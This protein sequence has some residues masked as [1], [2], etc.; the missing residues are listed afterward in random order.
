MKALKQMPRH[1][2]MYMI[3]LIL[4]SILAAVLW[5]SDPAHRPDGQSRINWP[6]ASTTKP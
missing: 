3:V 2:I 5:F 4:L 1:Q 6:P